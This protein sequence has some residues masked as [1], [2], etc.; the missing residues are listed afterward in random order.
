MSSITQDF[1]IFTSDSCDAYS[2]D[3]AVS[4]LIQGIS[5][6]KNS[7]SHCAFSYVRGRVWFKEIESKIR[8]SNLCYYNAYY[9]T[10]WEGRGIKSLCI[11]IET[12][13]GKR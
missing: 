1:I 9:S 6:S 5:Y 12:R 2:L 8:L 10:I 4:C 13:S 7:S 11:G 3:Q